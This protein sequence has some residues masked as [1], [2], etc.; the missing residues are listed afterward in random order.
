M[1]RLKFCEAQSKCAR[2]APKL[3]V[4]LQILRL[5]SLSY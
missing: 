5:E 2:G 4:G 3:V 1:N